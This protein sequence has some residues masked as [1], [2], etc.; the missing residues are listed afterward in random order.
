MTPRLRFAACFAAL[1]F[2]AGLAACDSEPDPE[3]E[4]LRAEAE[5][6]DDAP[7]AESADAEETG[8]SSAE[9]GD[10]RLSETRNI[11]FTPAEG[12]DELR[13]QIDQSGCQTAILEIEITDPEGEVVYD[14]DIAFS[15]FDRT[16]AEKTGQSIHEAYKGRVMDLLNTPVQPVTELN[17][18]EEEFMVGSPNLK[19]TQVEYEALR[20]SGL[21]YFCHWDGYENSVCIVYDDESAQAQTFLTRTPGAEEKAAEAED[22]APAQ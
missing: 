9:A 2:A 1:S 10:C 14:H 17:P 11:D 7:A 22:G 18:Y 4:A 19:L 8:T 21:N 3:L 12:D 13:V 6:A 5:D 16:A 20:N 15:A